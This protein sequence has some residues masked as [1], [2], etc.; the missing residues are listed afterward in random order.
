LNKT[1]GKGAPLESGCSDLVFQR[2][3]EILRN[4][5]ITRKVAAA[6]Q[7]GHAMLGALAM[8]ES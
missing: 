6:Q 8:S 7:T 2:F 4:V 5:P 3:P 1:I